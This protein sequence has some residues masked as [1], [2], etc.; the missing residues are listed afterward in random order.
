MDDEKIL[1]NYYMMTIPHVTVLSGAILGL[2]LLLR[3]DLKLALGLFSIFYGASLT[4]IA[5]IVRPQFGKLGLYR[6]SLFGFIFLILMGLLL[7]L[8]YL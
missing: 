4:I 6:I 2:L 1:L 5:I 8:P 7:I 3:L